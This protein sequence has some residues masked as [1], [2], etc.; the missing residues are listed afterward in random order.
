[1]YNIVG[2]ASKVEPNY[3]HLP[4]SNL[5]IYQK[6][7]YYSGIKFF[8]K[9]PLEIKNAAGNQK[10]FKTTLKK[11][12]FNDSFTQLKSTLINLESST[13]AQDF[14][15]DVYRLKI[16]VCVDYVSTLK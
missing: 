12:L 14:T 11:F 13:M 4:Q 15:I 2:T 1:M 9:L 3:L 16:S 10:K 7:A 8:N 6:A 5:T